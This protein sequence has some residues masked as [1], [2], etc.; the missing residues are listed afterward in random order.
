M[1]DP[2][3][4]TEARALQRRLAAI[5]ARYERRKA[6]LAAWL[7]DAEAEARQT[8]SAAARQILDLLTQ[9]RP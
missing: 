3:A 6:K 5:R 4:L 8:S 1:S 2:D 9:E 7:A